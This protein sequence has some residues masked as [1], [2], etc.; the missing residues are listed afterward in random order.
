MTDEEIRLMKLELKKENDSFGR[1]SW[2]A[3]IEKLAN[4]DVTKFDDVCRQNF[5]SCLNLLSY[6]LEKEKRIAKMQ[7]EANRT[8]TQIK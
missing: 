8:Q 3:M 5:I 4:G 6:W 1:W 2:F 7:E